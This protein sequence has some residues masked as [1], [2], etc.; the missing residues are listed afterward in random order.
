MAHGKETPRQKMIGMMYLVLT[1]MLALNVSKEVLD[2]FTLV[3]GGLTTTTQNFAAKNESLYDKFDIAFEQNPAKVGDWK[4]RADE[5]KAMSNELYEFINLCKIEIV[6]K[7]DEDA[8]VDG[9][10]HLADVKSKDDTNFPA[11]IM[12]VNKRGTE[13]KKK[14][15][16]YRE[17]L[18]TMIDDKET[19]AATVEAVEDILST[20]VPENLYHNKKK[21]ETPT[22]ESTY[23]EFLPLASVITLLSKMQGDVRNVEAEML[24]FLLGQVDAGDFKVNV[25]EPVVITNSNYVFKGQTYHAEVFLA[26]YDSTNI[27]EVK[28]ENGT[29][30]ETS[31]GKGIYEVSY[32]STGIRKWGG[33][34]S[35]EKDGKITSKPFS[36]E[37]EVAE[38]NAT[39]SATGM[40]VFYRGIPNPVEISVSGVAER[41]V[42]AQISSGNI[43]RVGAGT[44]EV[45]PGVGRGKATISVYANIDGQR[46]LMSRE[47]FRVYDLPKPDAVVEGIPGSEGA[48]TVGMLSQLQNVR[49]EA[50]DFVF[51][52]DYKVLSFEVAFAGSGGIWSSLPSGN[53]RFTGEQKNLFRQLRSGQ[54]IMIEKIKASGPDGVIRNLNS[55]TITVR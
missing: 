6:E 5:V 34:I 51:E 19:Y 23:F 24:N 31:G 28:L 3:D 30:L 49:A 14:I 32:N 10:V 47:D 25:I 29:I 18:L 53:D 40:N 22:W 12:L 27:P 15:E 4:T 8:I 1:A 43:K 41:D 26:A 38:S 21:G 48:L 37:F 54:R 11:E 36:A 55:I 42:I 33:V 39:V 13:L 16:D 17:F 52:V 46:K 20:E 7:R 35:I 44:Y 50:K 9:E 45:K 2:A